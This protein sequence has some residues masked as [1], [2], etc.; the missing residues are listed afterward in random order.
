MMNEKEKQLLAELMQYGYD[1]NIVARIKLDC[2]PALEELLQ[3]LNE[4]VFC[5]TWGY[6]DNTTEEFDNNFKHST[7]VRFCFT[8][9]L[10][11]AWLWEKRRDDVLAKGLYQCMIEARTDFEMDEYIEDI[12]GVDNNVLFPQNGTEKGTTESGLRS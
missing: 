1:R 7:V 5:S 9:G 12:T 10:G 4:Q 6:Y 11:A 2:D 8:A 3:E